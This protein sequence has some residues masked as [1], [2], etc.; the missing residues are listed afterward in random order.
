MFSAATNHGLLSA[1]HM[2][3]T[4]VLS[5]L[6]EHYQAVHGIHLEKVAEP[7]AAASESNGGGVE[8]DVEV[9][10]S[11]GSHISQ[12]IDKLRNRIKDGRQQQNGGKPSEQQQ[13]RN[14][15]NSSEVDGLQEQRQEEGDRL[16]ELAHQV[17]VRL[18]E[19][20]LVELQ[21]FVL[22]AC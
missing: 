9:T 8:D 13:Q 20:K 4:E 21:G 1:A 6:R 15:V 11:D 22:L 18:P 3:K 19:L 10:S 17:W 12:T 7:P 2:K 16:L 14:L 5:K